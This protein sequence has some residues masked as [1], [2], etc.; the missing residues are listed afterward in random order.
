MT[1]NV[2]VVTSEAVVLGCDSVSSSFHYLL[3]PFNFLERHDDGEIATDDRG[4][5]IAKF[6]PQF[7]Q[8]VVTHARSGVT[9]MFRLCGDDNPVAGTTAG[10]AAL[11]GKSISN[12]VSDYCRQHHNAQHVT[13]RSVVEEFSSFM[14]E[15]YDE[16]Y[17][18]DGTPQEYQWDVEFLIGGQGSSEPFPSLYRVNLKSA[19]GNAKIWP[20]YGSDFGLQR[21]GVAWAGQS[22][23]VERLIFG[24]DRHV[25]HL[26][27]QTVTDQ[28]A[29]MHQQMSQRV[30]G[31]VQDT[32]A[33]LNAPLPAAVDTQLPPLEPVA[34]PWASA[35]LEVDV[36]NMPLQDAIELAS[37]LVNLQSGKSIFVRGVPTVG[38]RTHI[39]LLQRSGFTM[40]NE[41]T[42]VHRNVGYDRS[43]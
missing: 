33:A 36:A 39:G 37:F 43:L 24:A 6:D 40:L 11:G 41:P 1:I 17:R 28:L 5:W 12:L 27:E 21:T 22:D 19:D 25:Q 18:M 8:N 42:L 14:R 38:G 3:D 4:Q 16:H 34:L 31:I 30:M 32:L 26:I 15:K 10:L 2:A 9:K 35:Q 13:V 20:L 23:A 7:I 29:R